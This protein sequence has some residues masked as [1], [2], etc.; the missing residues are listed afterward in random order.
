[1]YNKEKI[2]STLNKAKCLSVHSF[3]NRSQY[4]FYFIDNLWKDIKILIKKKINL[5]NLTPSPISASKIYR[6]LLG[7]NMPISKG[8]FYKSCIKSIYSKN[9]SKKLF[10][11]N[12]EEVK[13]NLK[14]FKYKY[15]NEISYL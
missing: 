2:K 5:I 14:I 7:A 11:Q 9:W 15:S 12:K 13:K 10:I 3:N 6:I 1:M 4:Q 8:K